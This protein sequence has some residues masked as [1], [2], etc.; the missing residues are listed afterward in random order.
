MRSVAVS[1]KSTCSHTLIHGT[2]LFIVFIVI[3]D[4]RPFFSLQAKVKGVECLLMTSHLESTAAHGTE[5]KRQL[6]AAFKA[7][8]VAPPQLTVFF[9]GDLN[10]RDKEV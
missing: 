8:Q 6:Q 5:R 2:F 10:L 3:H 1:C 4:G 7:M 9:G